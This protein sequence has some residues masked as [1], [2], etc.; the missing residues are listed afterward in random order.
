M[1]DF[2]FRDGRLCLTEKNIQKG[3]KS[4]KKFFSTSNLSNAK[5]KQTNISLSPQQSEEETIRVK[6]KMLNREHCRVEG[7][8]KD[9]PTKQFERKME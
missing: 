7:D 4:K 2:A 1:D 9:L 6:K 3:I 8:T 5:L